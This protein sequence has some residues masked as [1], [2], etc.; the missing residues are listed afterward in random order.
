MASNKNSKD[1]KY[2]VSEIL[3]TIN[4]QTDEMEG[5]EKGKVGVRDADGDGDIDEDDWEF[6]HNDLDHRGQPK[7][8]KK[9]SKKKKHHEED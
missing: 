5:R 1:K 6:D 8:K 2:K 4:E 9:K 3:G 7:K